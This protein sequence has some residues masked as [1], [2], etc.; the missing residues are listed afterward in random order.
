MRGG[1]RARDTGERDGS[2]A[3][4]DDQRERTPA[5]LAEPHRSYAADHGHAGSAD[6]GE[7]EEAEPSL[8]PAEA[9]G[10]ER[11]EG[12]GRLR[13]PGGGE[14]GDGGRTERER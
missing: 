9:R 4:P 3:G 10:G 11:G 13:H 2:G 8:A 6:E 1:E 14:P 7:Q 5:C 12:S